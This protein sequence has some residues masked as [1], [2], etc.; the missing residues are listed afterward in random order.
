MIVHVKELPTVAHAPSCSF[1]TTPCCVSSPTCHPVDSQET[2]ESPAYFPSPHPLNTTRGPVFSSL[3]TALKFTGFPAGI[4]DQAAII[5]LL[6]HCGSLTGLPACTLAP[7]QSHPS[8]TWQPQQ[9]RSDQVTPSPP[10][11][12]HLNT[13]QWLPL[14]LK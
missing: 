13:L 8:F 9:R 11:T 2:C 6:S 14:L 1:H 12:T 10:P 7:F 3:E 5:Y 4:L